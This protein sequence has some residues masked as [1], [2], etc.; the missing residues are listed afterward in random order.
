MISEQR[1]QSITDRLQRD[2][3]PTY[4]EV[5]DESHF[6]KEHP[7]AQ[8]GAGHFKVSISSPQFNNQSDISCHRLIYSAL[9][10]LMGGEIHALKIYLVRN[11]STDCEKNLSDG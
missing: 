5:V 10:D 6:H 8:N 9:A 3:S 2:L 7:G 4:L 1:L 11:H